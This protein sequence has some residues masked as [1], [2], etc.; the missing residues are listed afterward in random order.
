MSEQ[1]V[2]KTP[3]Y[4]SHSKLG[5]RLVPFAGYS[6]PVRY[7]EL[8]TEHEVVRNKA[9]IFDVSHMGELFFEG[10]E[11]LAALQYI[12]CNDVA[13]L[14]D[15]RA[16]YSAFLNEEG[17]VVDDIIVYRLSDQRYLVC[18]NAANVK[19][20]YAWCTEHTARFDVSL[21]NASSAYGQIALQGPLSEAILE[22]V[23]G[24]EVDLSAL[25]YFG[26]LEAASP[27]G[28]LI[29]ARTGYTGEDGFE[30][31][32]PWDATADLWEQLLQCGEPHGLLP[33][34]L[35]ARD[36]LRL[37]AC[38]PLHGHE[39][40]ED[41]PALES[42]LGWIIKTAKGDFIGKDAVVQLQAGGVPNKLVGFFVEGKGIVR[43]EIE[44]FCEAGERVGV[45]TSGT[46][47]PT[48]GK[49]LGLALV[50]ADYA[51][52]GTR[53]NASVRGRS[54]PIITV[55]TPFYRRDK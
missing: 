48:V 14:V 24:V 49:A 11:A 33:C 17:C 47:T 34:G 4:E 41:V 2:L 38:Y 5:G 18:V 32:V 43:E 50:S 16:Q 6:L 45:V 35:G 13:T 20:D 21:I 22:K 27:F 52:E 15:G 25:E 51:I 44:L 30:V 10:P 36:S 40:R 19:K 53:L 29:I 8:R 54:V 31:F 7:S 9:G 37:E 28:T 26:V 23:D 46:L 3:L 12:T 1:D 39:L 55:K 42:G